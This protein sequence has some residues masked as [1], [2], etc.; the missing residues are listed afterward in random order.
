MVFVPGR[1][2][3]SVGLN[4]IWKAYWQW[5]YDGGDGGIGSVG[6]DGMRKRLSIC[7]GSV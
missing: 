3:A 4:E 5:V 1:H 2:A 6:G 7:G